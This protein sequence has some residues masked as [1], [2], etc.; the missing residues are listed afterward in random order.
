MN[1]DRSDARFLELLDAHG[2]DPARWPPT[3]R[4]WMQ[5]RAQRDD[6]RAALHAA[7]ALDADLAQLTATAP[8]PS[9]R[10]AIL[11][12]VGE[13]VQRTAAPG[14]WLLALRS[15]WHELGGVRMAGPAMAMALAVGVGLGWMLEPA[16]VQSDDSSEDLM[17]LAQ[18]EDSYTELIP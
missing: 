13:G 2:G 1:T 7:L 9:L 15:L 11:V 17:A 6:L 5:Q 12:A 3:E 18:F 10:R 4:D 16:I 14:G 8:D